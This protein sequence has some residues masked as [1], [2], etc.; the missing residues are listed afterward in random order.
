MCVKRVT[1]MLCAFDDVPQY[2]EARV[3]WIVCL[4]ESLVG[5]DHMYIWS[6]HD[7]LPD[8]LLIPE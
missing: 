6:F 1:V 7:P 4:T 3:T 5:I 8:G 2:V